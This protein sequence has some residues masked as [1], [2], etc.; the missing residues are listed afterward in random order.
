MSILTVAT[1]VSV[2]PYVDRV[3]YRTHDGYF[4]IEINTIQNVNEYIFNKDIFSAI[5]IEIY[6]NSDSNR[7]N[8]IFYNEYY[9]KTYRMETGHSYNLW[10]GEIKEVISKDEPLFETYIENNLLIIKL[11]KNLIYNNLKLSHVH[12][13]NVGKNRIE[14]YK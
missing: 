4:Y 12:F 9:S 1:S 13:F 2:P 8:Q 6:F 3:N 7:D 11:D 5:S 10:W 14:T